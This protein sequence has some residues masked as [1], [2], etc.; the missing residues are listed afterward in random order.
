MGIVMCERCDKEVDLD[1]NA[2]EVVAVKGKQ[3]CWDCL[4]SEEQAVYENE[5]K[6][7]DLISDNRLREVFANANFG[8]MPNREVVRQAL[9]KC[10]GHLH[11]G[12]TAKTIL[13]ELGLVGK[14][15]T[16]TKKGARYLY[17]AYCGDNDI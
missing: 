16:L 17:F 7:S 15:Y 1:Y 12:Y 9:L 13:L 10:A 14:N 8:N 6:L 2:Q 4:T 3:M 5:Q 11:Q